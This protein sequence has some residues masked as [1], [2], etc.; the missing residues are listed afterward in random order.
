MNQL[1]RFHNY[2]K[3]DTWDSWLVS[4]ILII[5]FIRLI[6]F[7]GLSLI[8]NTSLPLV[9]VESCSMYHDSSFDKWWSAVE[10]SHWYSQ[11]NIEKSEFGTF[12]FKSGLN[13]G[14]IIFVWGRSEY[15]KGDIIIFESNKESTAKHPLIHRIVSEN[16]TA[17]KGD[18]NLHQLALSN[19]NKKI[20]ETNIQEKQIIGKSVAKI[21]L[22]GWLKLIFFEPFRPSSQRGFCS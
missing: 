15:K 1:K 9:V 8:T 16:P 19:N 20:D 14:D 18:N 17:T 4:L 7:P 11:N 21:P 22:L 2:L 12:P 13:K 5:I 3:K 10:N 6:F